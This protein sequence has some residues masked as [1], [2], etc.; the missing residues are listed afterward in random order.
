[1]TDW[2]RDYYDSVDG[3]DAA[4]VARHFT[5]DGT[6]RLGNSPEA[7]GRADIAARNQA[8]FDTIAAM[9]RTFTRQYTVGAVDIVEADV[10]YTLEDGAEVA[11]PG[12]AVLEREGDLITASHSYFD[13]GPFHELSA[14]T[15][16]VA[17]SRAWVE[18]FISAVDTLD[19]NRMPPFF[20]TSAT[21][22]YGNNPPMVGLEHIRA[23]LEPFHA[24]IA[25]I[26]HVVR[27]CF[28]SGPNVIVAE[29]Q[30]T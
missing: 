19:V 5:E 12:I 29:Y 9:K 15:S 26:S 16:R 4:G 27:N 2:V 28:T 21:F 8:F 17:G 11:I 10:T 23:G 18:R 20:A 25:G 3:L 14:R 7:E 30:A 1:M 22:T 6:F 24:S 13:M